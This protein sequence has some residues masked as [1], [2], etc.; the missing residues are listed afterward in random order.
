MSRMGR[1]NNVL[2]GLF[3]VT[4][5]VLAVA[6]AFVLGDG[7]RLFTPRSPYQ[8]YFSVAQGA[9]GLEAGSPVTIGGK[10]VG[11]VV[12][13]DFVPTAIGSNENGSVDPGSVD[14]GSV[15]PAFVDPGAGGQIVVS[16]E[17]QDRV[18]VYQ[19]ARAEVVVPLLGT[20]STINFTDIGGPRP[21]A[22]GVALLEPGG[23]L[24]GYASPA[25]ASQLG[26]DVAT[27]NA[28]VADAAAG[29]RTVRGLLDRAQP[30]VGPLVD[31]AAAGAASFRAVAQAFAADSPA[32]IGR[33]RSTLERVQGFTDRLPALGDRADSTLVT[34]ERAAGDI[35]L[36]FEE[37]RANLAATL[38]GT[39]S[40]IGHANREF[41][42]QLGSLLERANRAAASV[43]TA[44]AQLGVLLIA[45]SPSIERS[46]AN[47]SLATDRAR[48]LIE[49]ISNAPWRLLDS[50]SRKERQT[51]DVYE[52]ARIYAEATARL[53]T[54]SESLLALVEAGRLGGPVAFR[55]DPERLAALQRQIEASQAEVQ[56]IERRLLEVLSAQQP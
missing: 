43:D 41:R 29:L 35:A 14:L 15:D 8:V 32:I 1:R 50:P 48:R 44:S 17:L 46:F 37:N 56:T 20:L 47:I 51:A 54:A 26:I 28:A 9:P 12:S 53:Q 24:R 45:Q 16:I 40:F 7:T 3:L 27:L 52:A 33:V 23:S 30:S 11:R 19:N 18:R 39:A 34:L 4:G 6:A 13:V 25:I 5:L 21:G 2:A 36:V 55:V 49:E 42:P 22:L 10:K 38:D 31:D